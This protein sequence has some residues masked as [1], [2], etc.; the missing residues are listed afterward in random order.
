M[1]AF[2]SSV[3]IAALLLASIP[4]AGAQSNKFENP[5]KTPHYE[6]NVP[7]HGTTLPA[8]PINVVLNFNFDLHKKSSISIKMG[9]KEYGVGA[10]TIDSSKL[11]M[12][13]AVSP[14]APNGKYTVSYNACWPDG[15]CHQGNFAFAINKNDANAKKFQNMRNKK[16]VTV[17]LS[18]VKFQP[19]Q[20]RISKGTKVT[21]VNDDNFEHSINSDPHPGHNYLPAQNSPLLK[22]GGKFSMTF[23]TPGFYPYHCSPHASFMKAAIIVE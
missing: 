7:E 1:R 12:R 23:S 21:W 3:V 14:S 19:A 8:A 10:L 18:Q 22:R 13:M 4:A 5:K 9:N 17:R 6:S 16:E 20:I 15:S 2:I 11:A